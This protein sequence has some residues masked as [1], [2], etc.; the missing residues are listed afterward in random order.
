MLS[1]SKQRDGGR[2]GQPQPESELEKQATD[3]Q[4]SLSPSLL[5][6]N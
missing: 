5:E 4:A 2:W 1:A 3:G 6:P